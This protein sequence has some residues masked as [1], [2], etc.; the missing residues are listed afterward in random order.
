MK[1]FYIIIAF[2]CFPVSGLCQK[3]LTEKQMLED[4]DF[5][6]STVMDYCSF[7]P[8]LEQRSDINISREF[9]TLKLKVEKS[10]TLE[11]FVDLVRQGLNIV[12]DGHT[13]IV[14]SSPVK[15]FATNSY[16]AP[17]GNVA[18]SDTLGTDYYYSLNTDSLYRKIGSGIRAKYIDGIYYN[19]RPFTCNNIPIRAGEK[20][21]AIDGIE[22]NKFVNDHRFEMFS[23]F[24]DFRNNQWYSDNFMW[25]MPK[26]GKSSFTLAI[27]GKE[28]VIDSGKIVDNLEKEHPQSNSL[29]IVKIL[30]NNILYIY[31]P[32]MMD[33]NRYI[34]EIETVYS[35]NIEKIV[36]DLRDNSGGDD[37]VWANIM[38]AIIDKPF[39]YRYQVGMYNND[40][41]KESVAQFGDIRIDG[42]RM[43]VGRDRVID[44]DEESLNFSGHIYI[45]QNE[46][47]YSAASAF[48][49]AALQ[50]K[51]T[52][53]VVGVPT[54][55]LSGYTFPPVIFKL[56]NSGIAFKL[57][58]SA[59][60]TGGDSN[61]YMQKVDVEIRQ[62]I[63]DYLDS[64]FGNDAKSTEYLLNK[65]K[66]IK[67]VK[68]H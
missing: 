46:W 48:V 35:P 55:V 1:I 44:P 9:D 52:M 20:I 63:D 25:L 3:Q 6:K 19:A 50:N 58:F 2:L 62:N 32:V 36:F 56:P 23:L 18:L 24:W 51:Q 42:G 17:A 67:Y 21:T 68:E 65:D 5:L 8:L 38:A 34:N 27:G 26:I 10:T 14:G 4:I 53:T 31:M 40:K 54:C 45:L 15:W 59:D 29:P 41:L 66:L 11:E 16:L 37:S 13:Q 22:I 28:V 33:A 49:S 39:K 61:P 43:T 7:V 57:A 12:N 64:L 47:T 60:L 30:D